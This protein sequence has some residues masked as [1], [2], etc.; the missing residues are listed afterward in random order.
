MQRFD[1]DSLESPFRHEPGPRSANVKTR[2]IAFFAI[3][4]LSLSSL[5]F[6]PACGPGQAP[7]NPLPVDASADAAADAP[8]D[9]A[10]TEDAATTDAADAGD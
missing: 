10:K 6:L 5:V 8:T 1:K 3:A 2:K 4:T 7:P 9:G